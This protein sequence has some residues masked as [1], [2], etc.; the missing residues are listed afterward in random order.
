MNRSSR[1]VRE[2]F[3]AVL[4]IVSLMAS[5]LVV[6]GPNAVPEAQAAPTPS[7]TDSWINTAGGDWGMAGNWSSDAVPTNSDVACLS[8]AGNYTVEVSATDGSETVGGLTMGG[9]TGNQILEI[10]AC[11]TVTAYGTTTDGSGSA[12]DNQG[13]F[14][15][16]S[17]GTF[18]Q[19]DGTTDGVP[20]SVAG[21]LDFT[22]TGSSAFS[23]LS[24][25]NS[26]VSGDIEA[27]QS[28]TLHA[29]D[30]LTFPDSATNAGT[31]D[32]AGASSSIVVS[33]G[34]LTNTGTIDVESGSPAGLTGTFDNQGTGSDGI[35]D[36]SSISSGRDPHQPR[37]PGHRCRRH[38]HRLGH[39]VQQL[40][41]HRRRRH[42]QR[43]LQRDA[44]IRERGRHRATRSAWR[45]SSTSPAPASQASRRRRTIPPTSPVTS[46]PA[47]ASP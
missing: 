21:D 17:V 30:D 35:V 37:L 11:A 44:S 9:T 26:Q 36:D 25:Y 23:F 27:D 18:D 14:T 40:R 45:A 28:I 16:P 19:D 43:Q 32:V 29:G 47:R 41:H 33:S 1:T 5:A 10:D 24:G 39:G 22:G 12:I 15:V 4:G 8:A 31:I 38:V 42:P 3:W 6:I 34:T 2:S 7:C 20:I 13:T 46:P